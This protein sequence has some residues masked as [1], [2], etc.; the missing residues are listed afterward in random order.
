MAKSDAKVTG[1]VYGNDTA[2]KEGEVAS[3]ETIYPGMLVEVTGDNGDGDPTLQPCQNVDAE[4]PVRVVLTP[5]SPPKGNDS[6]I[7]IEHEYSAGENVQ[8]YVARPGDEIQNALLAN[9]EN[10]GGLPQALGANND[11]SL[12]TTT[13]NGATLA[14]ALEDVDN[15]GGGD[16]AGISAA[17]IDVEVK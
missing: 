15:S 9:G 4:I 17:R 13:T 1:K 3:G 8:Y 2:Y 12:A 5:E 10:V 11:G 14:R 7:P 16:Q 6:D